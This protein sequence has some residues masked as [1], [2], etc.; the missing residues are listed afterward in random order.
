MAAGCIVAALLLVITPFVWGSGA[1]RREISAENIVDFEIPNQD[2]MFLYL[3]DIDYMPSSS[4][5]YDV[6]RKDEI[7]G[8]GKISLRYDGG[9]LRSFNK[10]YWAHATSNLDFDLRDYQDYDYLT[11]YVGVN[12]AANQ[13][14]SVKFCV[15]TSAAETINPAVASEWGQALTSEQGATSCDREARPSDDAIFVKIPIKGVNYIRFHANRNGS[16]ASDHAVYGDLKLIKEGYQEDPGI[17]A[18]VA[19]LDEK[20]KSDGGGLEKL[21]S[22]DPDYEIMVLRRNLVKSASKWALAQF[23]QQGEEELEMMRWLYNDVDALRMY[24]TGGAPTGS[25]GQSLAVLA[26]L[27]ATYK[28]D[29]NDVTPVAGRTRGDLYQRMMMAIALTHSKQVRFWIRDQGEMAGNPES[30]NLSR[31]L[32]RYAVYKQMYLSG[33]LNNEIFEPLEVEEMR[34]LMFT[35]LGDD[36]LEWI[37]DWTREKGRSP[38][39]YPPVPYISIGSHYWWDVNYDPTYIDPK[40][41]KTWEEV[42]SLRG[43]NYTDGEDK[44]IS[45]NYLI[46]FEAKAPHLWMI[47]YYGGVCWQ[48]SN[49]GQNVVASYGIPGTTLGQPGHLAYINY[50]LSD[51]VPT[52]VLRN[53]VSGWSQSNFTGYTNT[54]TYHPVRQMNNWGTMD[55]TYALLR[56]RYTQQ[57]SYIVLAQAAI[58]D[59]ENYEDAELLVKMAKSFDDDLA[60]QEE[61]YRE[62]IAKQDF[63][64][65]AWYGLLENYTKRDDVT[66]KKW[67]D[68]AID[69]ENSRMRNFALPFHD[70]VQTII[71]RIPTESESVG[72]NLATELVLRRSLE[73]MLDPAN[74]TKVRINGIYHQQDVTRTLA[75]ALLGRLNNEIA[76]FSFDGEDAGMLKLG[77]KYESSQAAFEFSLDGGETWLGEN[78]SVW[79]GDGRNFEWVTEKRIQLTDEQIAAINTED[80]ILVHIQGVPREGNIYTIDIKKAVLPTTLY[81]NDKENRVVGVNTTMQWRTVTMEGE[82]KHYG[83]WVPYAEESPL[84]IGDITIQVRV[85]ATGVYLPSD[86]SVEYR[87]TKDTDPD[88]RKYVPTSHLS[89]AAASSQATG[90]GQL[91]NAFY[92]LD[93]NFNTRW[94][95]AWNG[96]DSDQWIVVKFDHLVNLAAMGYV[97][98]GGG[99]GRILQGKIYVSTEEN[100]DVSNFEAIEQN[101]QHVGTVADD[102]VETDGL[103]CNES[104]PNLDNATVTNL[105]ARTFEFRRTQERPVLDEE[106]N[107]VPDEND[108]PVME[109]VETHSAIPARYVAIKATLTSRNNNF[110]AARMLNFYEDRTHSLTPTAGV[111]YSTIEPTN[112][113]VIA[114]L[115]N[116]TEEEIEAVDEQGNVIERGGF[117]HIFHENGE[118]T[119]RFRK[120]GDAR[121]N[122]GMA[123]AKVDWIMSEA[124]LPE[125]VEYVCVDDNIDGNDQTADCSAGNGKTNRSVSVKLVFPE[126]TQIKVLNNGL[127]EEVPDDG[128]D[129]EAPDPG[130]TDPDDTISKDENSRDP[131]TYLFMRNGSFTFEYE[132]AAGNRRGYP[133]KVDWIDKAAPKVDI[134]YST[135]EETDGEV[136]ATLFSVPK[137]EEVDEGIVT[138][139]DEEIILDGVYDENGLE[140]GEDFIMMNGEPEY[141]FTENGEYT[142]EYRDEAGNRGAMVAKVDWIRQKQEPPVV[143]DNPG[144][145]ESQ[146]P[147]DGESQNPDEADPGQPDDVTWPDVLPGGN[148]G[149]NEAQDKPVQNRPL[150]STSV[151]ADNNVNA[152]DADDKVGVDG[153]GAMVEATGLPEGAKVEKKRLVLPSNLM[154]RFGTNSELYELS[155]VDAQGKTPELVKMPLTKGK[156]LEGIY[157]VKDDG[158]TEKVGFERIDNEYIAIK[159]PIEGKYL[160]KYEAPKTG[161]NDDK[162][163]DKDEN[164]TE[165]VQKQ[166]FESPWLLG[167]A[168]VVT[169]VIVGVAVGMVANRRR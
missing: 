17:I 130:E 33:K 58:N 29:L 69:M 125:R 96:S 67:Y 1:I 34:Y 133:V 146:D 164:A 166:W 45:G 106:G 51:G 154:A 100:P 70:L 163:S 122:I 150:G 27:Y 91:G 95:S 126:G 156:T 16:N 19:E 28:D 6:I 138:L 117:E 147:S 57:G 111:A 139:G 65:D 23:V 97:A 89:V 47:N 18:D 48:I 102:C 158:A 115:V 109:E 21:K 93:G 75:N 71:T 35:E 127:Q 24:T 85:G 52:L 132:D 50:A 3:S 159:N 148:P 76:V 136:V 10:G 68:L 30:P 39:N 55:G 112:T 103:L 78:G 9:Q 134:R 49:F 74:N 5:Q 144:G 113:S 59:F 41:G 38:Y 137:P 60:K 88:T 25:Y 165:E 110:I 105:N 101:F 40:S 66:A 44:T 98:A 84:R 4:T 160:F 155:F 131:F 114:R 143:P 104:W 14:G 11:G 63:N 128:Y 80:D 116:T 153:N 62:A 8:G 107:P 46:G 15:F 83:E 87:F 54:N 151:V 108:E 79:S 81:A 99:N 168:A 13:V 86:A 82:E 61:I 152:G 169:V 53:D 77:S 145:D 161:T 162:T 31:P 142:F 119:F 92:A 149:M 121:D 141:H 22:G 90:N 42:Y 32:D 72:Y 2:G 26:Q 118:Y 123:I 7:N 120:V 36:E 135:I 124:P 56:N 12:S 64:F 37:N 167:G 43:D 129:T 140:Y 20:L 94:H 73:W 157:I